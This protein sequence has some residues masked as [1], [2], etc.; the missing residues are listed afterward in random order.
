MLSAIANVV[1]TLSNFFL[2]NVWTFSDQQHQGSRLIRGFLSFILISSVSICIT[3][4]AYAGISEMA[5]HLLTTTFHR[6]TLGIPMA[7]QLVAIPL[8]AGFSYLLNR[9]FTWPQTETNSSA[10]ITQAQEI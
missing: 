1:S 9:K 6:S 4:I 3:T 7:C 5:S 8:G 2:H 10:D